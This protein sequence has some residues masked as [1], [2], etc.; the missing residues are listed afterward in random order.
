MGN[1]GRGGQPKQRSKQAS[2]NYQK[3]SFFG[4]SRG[5]ALWEMLAVGSHRRVHRGFGVGRI[6]G[7][8]AQ[9]GRSPARVQAVSPSAS[10][11]GEILGGCSLVRYESGRF[12]SQAFV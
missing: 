6:Y 11:W 1:G 7:Q 8:G 2:S 10:G 12:G 9:R 4:N 5:I 3:L